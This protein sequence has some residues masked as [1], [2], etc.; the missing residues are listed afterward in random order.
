MILLNYDMWLWPPYFIILLIISIIYN[1]V[2]D[3][4]ILLLLHNGVG[5]AY[6]YDWAQIVHKK[7]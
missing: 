6:I 5:T 1:T 7:R 4:L 2:V 3:W